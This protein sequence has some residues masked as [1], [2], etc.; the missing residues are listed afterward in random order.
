MRWFSR[1]QNGARSYLMIQDGSFFRPS[2]SGPKMAAPL[3][4]WPKPRYLENI[5][6]LATSG[7]EIEVFPG[8]GRSSRVAHLDATSTRSLS[9][10]ANSLSLWPCLASSVRPF[11]KRPIPAQEV[12]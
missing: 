6:T 1:Q 4:C 8:C 3:V 7:A 9:D 12:T 10:T 2:F 11:R 5:S